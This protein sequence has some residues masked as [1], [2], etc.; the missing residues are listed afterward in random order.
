MRNT[1]FLMLSI[2]GIVLSA[3]GCSNTEALAKAR[4]DADAARKEAGKARAEAAKA[5]EELA[6][7]KVLVD[8]KPNPKIAALPEDEPL[9]KK[10]LDLYALYQKNAVGLLEWGHLKRNI[11]DT[12]PS[13]VSPKDAPTLGKRLIELKKAYDQTALGLQEWGTAKTKVMAQ[14]PVKTTTLHQELLD[15]KEA[16]DQNALGLQEWN[17]AKAVVSKL[18]KGK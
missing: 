3:A 12:I 4:A 15:L 10:F 13:K 6:K 11:L 16:Y 9:A 2:L 7:L 18:L 17:Q 1:L 8:K 5:L 14:T